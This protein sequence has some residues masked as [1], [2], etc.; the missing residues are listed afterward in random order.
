MNTKWYWGVPVIFATTSRLRRM[1]WFRIA[2]CSSLK[3][4]REQEQNLHKAEQRDLGAGLHAS[5]SPKQ[6][7]AAPQVRDSLPPFQ[8]LYCCHRSDRGPFRHHSTEKC[9]GLE[10]I[11]SNWLF[12]LLLKCQPLSYRSQDVPRFCCQ[13]NC[14][15][16]VNL[17]AP[18]KLLSSMR[19]TTY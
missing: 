9:E 15:S 18:N 13:G 11:S 16:I 2:N 10:A 19:K 12:K 6:A 7:E 4:G 14:L 3:F 8:N 5:S 17:S 1:S